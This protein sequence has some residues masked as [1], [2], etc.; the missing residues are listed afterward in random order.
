MLI[1]DRPAIALLNRSGNLSKRFSRNLNKNTSL[2]FPRG[3]IYA[4]WLPVP[5][6]FHSVLSIALMFY[7]SYSYQLLLHDYLLDILWQLLGVG[8]HVIQAEPIKRRVY[9]LIMSFY[10]ILGH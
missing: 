4:V 10:S 3:K 7:A 9:K 2:F 8:H 5:S 1:S 6:L